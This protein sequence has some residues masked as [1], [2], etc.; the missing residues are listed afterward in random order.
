MDV[1]RHV[2]V[3][4]GLLYSISIN[5][6]VLR[7]IMK[8]SSAK[9]KSE[10]Q[11]P[12]SPPVPLESIEDIAWEL[13]LLIELLAPVRRRLPNTASQAGRLRERPANRKMCRL[14][15]VEERPPGVF[16]RLRNSGS[17]CAARRE[18]DFP[19][20]QDLGGCDRGRA[21]FDQGPLKGFLIR[22]ARFHAPKREAI[23]ICFLAA[24]L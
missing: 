18:L 2:F 17:G 11:E 22:S 1:T 19:G 13:W 9:R 21:N 23:P 8:T 5:L 7:A 14:S 12:T 24:D 15:Q 3:T 16:P 20:P 10:S 6:D 4:C